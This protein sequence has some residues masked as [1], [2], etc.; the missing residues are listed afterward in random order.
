[1]RAPCSHEPNEDE[2]WSEAAKLS[3]KND[4]P[5]TEGKQVDLKRAE[6]VAH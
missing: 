1:M 3:S 6:D 2:A 4:K 5:N